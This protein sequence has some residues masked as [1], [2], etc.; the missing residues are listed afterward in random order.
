MS[1]S[2]SFRIIDTICITLIC[3]ALIGGCT[4]IAGNARAESVQQS[5]DKK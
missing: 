2:T 5:E 3:L 1:K 4:Y